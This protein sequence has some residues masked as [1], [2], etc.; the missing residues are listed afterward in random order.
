MKNRNLFLRYFG[1]F[2]F[3]VGVIF[4]ILMFVGNA[5]PTYLYALFCLIGILQITISNSSKKIVITWQ[6]LWIII[7]FVIMYCYF[8][9]IN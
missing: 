9:F 8:H 1:F 7:P 2:I 5:W 3:I 6:I 4:N